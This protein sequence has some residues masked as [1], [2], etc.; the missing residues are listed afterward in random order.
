MNNRKTKSSADQFACAKPN[1]LEVKS[2]MTGFVQDF[3]KFNSELKSKLQTQEDR[4][5]MLE[6]KTLKTNRPVLSGAVALEAPHQK[7]F[8]A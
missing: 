8:S 5:S 2:A 1:S 4:L 7:A 3:S 6:R